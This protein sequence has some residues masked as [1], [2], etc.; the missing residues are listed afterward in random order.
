MKV[1]SKTSLLEREKEVLRLIDIFKENNLKFIV[2]GGYAVS[3]YKKR[4]S[5][6]LDIVIKED[7]LIKFEKVLEKQGFSMGYEKEIALLYGENFKRFRKKMN[8]LPVDVDLLINGLVSRTTD[9]TWSFESIYKNSQK[10]KLYNLEFLTPIRELLVSMKMHSGRLSDVRDIIALM[11]CNKD[12]LKEF[13]LRGNLSNLKA[14]IK[15]Q[16]TFIEKSQFDDSFKGIFG[17]QAYD[18]KQI[19]FAKKLFEALSGDIK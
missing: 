9:A 19:E 4:F 1:D 13:L 14:S 12:K 11:P 3:T 5:V 6:D 2:I 17:I 10:R 7:D 16:T 18:K 8:D 15:N